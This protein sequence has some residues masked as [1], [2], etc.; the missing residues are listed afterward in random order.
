M[1]TIVKLVI[2]SDQW[3]NTQGGKAHEFH[4]VFVTME[5]ALTG[6][7]E[8][9]TAALASGEEEV[10]INPASTSDDDG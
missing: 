7:A 6:I 1:P 9:A 8:F 5:D 3:G 10:W 4:K 2:D